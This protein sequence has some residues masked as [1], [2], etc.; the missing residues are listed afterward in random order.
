MRP[1][2]L[3][4]WLTLMFLLKKKATP[5]VILSV[6]LS[7]SSMTVPKNKGTGNA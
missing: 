4:G 6:L 5:S 3:E 7:K 1:T 2:R